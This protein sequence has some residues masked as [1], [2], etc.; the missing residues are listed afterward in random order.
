MGRPAARLRATGPV[1]GESPIVPTSTGQ[2]AALT[3]AALAAAAAPP[4]V[5]FVPTQRAPQGTELPHRASRLPDARPT[6]S[7]RDS[8]GLRWPV[9]AVRELAADA[10]T[11]SVRVVPEP[12]GWGA[13]A[14][15]VPVHTG[16]QR[17]PTF[18]TS[19]VSTFS[20]PTPVVPTASIPTPAA[21]TF[22]MPTPVVT[23][24]AT[25]APP[26]APTWPA[27]S[28][29]PAMAEPTVAAPIAVVVTVADAAP[30]AAPTAAA[31]TTPTTTTPATEHATPA[32]GPVTY[33]SRRSMR[34]T[35]SRSRRAVQYVAPTV[36]VAGAFAAGYCGHLL[37][38]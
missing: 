14:Y 32:A 21:P 20:M 19:G 2:H 23:R 22:S 38:G 5:P 25:P 17:V 36:A 24:Q 11:A 10:V 18:P 15:P 37:L 9:D 8:D 4:A 27:R 31:T 3:P 26:A 30:P 28:A 29:L 16:P 1:T 34:P 6:T 33:P 13:A 7:T 12:A 35:R